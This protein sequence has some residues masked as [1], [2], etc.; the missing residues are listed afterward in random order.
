MGLTPTPPLPQ[1]QEQQLD[2]GVDAR[3]LGIDALVDRIAMDAGVSSSQLPEKAPDDD[4]STSKP[5]EQTLAVIRVPFAKVASPAANDNEFDSALVESESDVEDVIVRRRPQRK[6]RN[7]PLYL[8]FPYWN[9]HGTHIHNTTVRDWL[10]SNYAFVEV[11]TEHP[12]DELLFSFNDYFITRDHF[13][14]LNSGEVE[15]VFLDV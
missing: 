8:R 13:T 7:I 10:I 15:S 3:Q 12:K 11:S 6:F 5:N 1:Q 9:E 4:V 14:T 2:A